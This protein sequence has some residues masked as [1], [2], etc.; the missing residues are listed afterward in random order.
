[1]RKPDSPVQQS[2]QE[3]SLTLPANATPYT[4]DLAA[5]QPAAIVSAWKA[6]RQA[7]S[8]PV[9]MAVLLV[10]VALIGIHERLP[11]PDTWWHIAVGERI[12]QSHSWP[13]SDPYSFTAPG[14]HWIA[15]E[16]LGE[17]AM[18]LAAQAGGLSALA[19]LLFGLVGAITVL[20]YTY[21]YV[22]C[23]NAKAACIAT[24]ILLPIA[25]AVFTLRPQLFGYV[26]LLITLICLE[27]FRQGH[28]KALWVLPPLFLVWVNT[29]GTF[30]LGLMAIGLYY[31]SGLFEFHFGEL[32]AEP[33]TRKQRLQLL[34]TF[35]FCTLALLVTP[36]G[37]QLAAYPIEIATSQ[38]VNI[39]NIQEWRPLSFGM[40]V[41]KYVLALVLIMF[42]VHVLLPVK[43]RLHEMALLLF[44]AYATCVHLR[45]ILVFV[46]FLGPII[47]CILA[48]WAPPYNREK[49]QPLLNLAIIALVTV[50]V[51]KYLPSKA[52]LQELVRKDYPVGAVEYLRLHPQPTRMFNAYG[53]GGYLI[54][55]LGSQQK[56]FIDGRA[57]VYEYGGVFRDYL[58][59]ANLNDNALVLLGKYN[60]GSCLVGRKDALATL[61]SALPDWKRAYSDDASMLF[62][63]S[64][65]ASP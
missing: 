5:V 23:G 51:V 58:D 9:L 10:A 61:L 6:I 44:G 47:A 34:L 31:V 60:I 57:D 3:S 24:G 65:S 54:W 4:P 12:L 8:F 33:W 40:G 16:W 48:R 7:I 37:S 39:A 28:S 2:G 43:Y 63:R 13:T 49:D 32:S 17:V 20:L 64:N 59:I 42:L 27:R 45:F 29:H 30:V 14:A 1:M 55:Q 11:D 62:V 26:F 38:P 19:A 50:A 52:D 21:F 35:L 18:A 25:A 41:G 46:M 15:Y 36:Y 22:R 53:F 56:V